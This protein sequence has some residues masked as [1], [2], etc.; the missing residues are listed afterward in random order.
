MILLDILLLS[1][2]AS[3]IIHNPPVVTVTPPDRAFLPIVTNLASI[4]WKPE[5]GISWQIQ[6]SG[7]LDISL[8]VQMYDLDLFDTPQPTIDQL[9]EQERRVV[10]YFSAGSWENWRE[11]ADQFPEEIL[12]KPLEGWPDEKWL[13]LRRIDALGPIMAARLDLAKQKDCDGVDPDNLDGYLNDSGFPLTFDDQLVY[14]TWMAQQAH[15]RGLG[16][17]LKNDLGQ[18]P[19]LLAYYDWALNE[20]CFQY[21][22]C[23]LLLPFIQAGKPVFGI[24]Y[25]GNPAVFCPQ[26]NVM[27]FDFL[28]KNLELDVWR[29]ACR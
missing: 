17:G 15:I 26:A 27:N 11:D 28:K 5:P 4:Y 16:V 20:Q 21:N 14:N 25:L 29:V 12:G 10:C 3:G 1:C 24:E 2:V 19:D 22:E 13:D 8:D 18:I 9:H 23:E 6:F 7:E